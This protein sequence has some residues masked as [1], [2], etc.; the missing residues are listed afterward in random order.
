M[1]TLP[2]HRTALL[3]RFGEAGIALFDQGFVSAVNFLTIVLLARALSLH[4][5]GVFMLARAIRG[6]KEEPPHLRFVVP[7]GVAGGF[8]VGAGAAGGGRGFLDERVPLPA[9]FAAALPLGVH[10]AAGLAD[11]A[12]L[13]PGHVSGGTVRPGSR[14]WRASCRRNGKGGGP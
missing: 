4:D 9:P 2:T 7:V 3:N 13:L 6:P 1:P 5:F 12:G 14:G 10:G 11:E 8:W